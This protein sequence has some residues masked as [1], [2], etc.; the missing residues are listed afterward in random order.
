MTKNRTALKTKVQSGATV[1]KGPTP[2]RNGMK[3]GPKISRWEEGRVDRTKEHFELL[4]G[5]QEDECSKW[6][7]VAVVGPP[8]A[9]SA[10]VQFLVERGDPRN[11]DVVSD[12]AREIQYYLIDLGEQDPWGYA[13]YHCGTASNL[14]GNVHWSFCEPDNQV[15]V[16]G[17]AET[18]STAGKRAA[19]TRKHRVA[20][21]KAAETR[22]RQTAE[23]VRC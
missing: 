3:S 8:K 16:E 4:Y 10:Q 18:E 15:Q 21:R 11:A 12:T 14:Y 7:P 23:G 19:L 22:K 5:S 20:A 9:S 2:E 13:K 6:T 17:S 1:T